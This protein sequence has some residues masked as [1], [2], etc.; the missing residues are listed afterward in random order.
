MPATLFHYELGR[1]QKS[2]AAQPSVPDPLAS[3]TPG[4]SESYFQVGAR[5]FCTSHTPSVVLT[6]V[7]RLFP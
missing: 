6:G 1:I 4:G 2:V 5:I 3:S 7:R